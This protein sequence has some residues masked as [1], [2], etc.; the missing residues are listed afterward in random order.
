LFFAQ[1]L[2]KISEDGKILSINAKDSLVNVHETPMATSATTKASRGYFEIPFWEIVRG[3]TWWLVTLLLLQ[4]MS[5]V[6]LIRF[7]SVLSRHMVLTMFLTMLTG[8]AGNAGNQSSSTV[9]AALASGELSGRRNFGRVL[10]RELRC[11]AISGALLGIAA[12]VRVSASRGGSTLAATAV[13]ASMFTTV[14]G[15]VA[16]GKYIYCIKILN[17]I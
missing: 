15:A 16:I 10:R 9:I 14:L 17:K 13:G 7:E 3:R 1:L 11:A 2:Q 6:I 8:T 4:S 5:S 12:F